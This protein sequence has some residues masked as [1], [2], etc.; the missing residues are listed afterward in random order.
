MSNDDIFKQIEKKASSKGSKGMMF[1]MV[2][3]FAAFVGFLMLNPFV[4]IDAG[5]RGVV[6]N[7]G[8]VQD[9]VMDE[10]LHII[11]PI[12]QK[13]VSMD[14]TIQKSQTEAVAASSDIQETSSVIALNYHIDPDKANWVYQNLRHQVK[15][16]IIDPA[17]QEVVK[18]VTAR[19]NAVDLITKRAKVGQDIKEELRARLLKSNIIVDE[20]SI[21]DFQFGEQFS[22]AIESKQTA[23]QLALKAARDLDRI[24]IEAEQ[25]LTQARAEAEGLRLQKEVI[26]EDLI[27][28]RQIEA[29]MM[30]IE[31]WDGVM[32]RVTG[33]AL[34]FVDA[35]DY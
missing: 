28:L 16:R 19:Y 1:L 26:S 10:G 32:P 35:K 34:P 31:K 23:E 30:A 14:V 21:I 29:T 11:I 25:K 9:E 2:L 7:F 6:L 12:M 17:V 4:Q 8:E 33:G 24:T 3:L 18:A 13:V 15:S 5:T 20:F 27:K 22:R